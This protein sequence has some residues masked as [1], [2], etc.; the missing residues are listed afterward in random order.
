MCMG[1][2]NHKTSYQIE[3]LGVRINA[4]AIIPKPGFMGYRGIGVTLGGGVG[5][6]VLINLSIFPG[7]KTPKYK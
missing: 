5:V 1:L 4:E 6:N 2:V 3:L 7:R